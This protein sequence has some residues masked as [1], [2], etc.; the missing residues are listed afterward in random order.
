MSTFNRTQLKD[1]SVLIRFTQVYCQGQHHAPAQPIEILPELA[2]HFRHGVSLCPE[3]HR[4]L[5]YALHK[6][7]LCPLDPKPACKHCHI[8]CYSAEHRAK[9]REVM[10]FAGRQLIMRGRLHYLWHYFF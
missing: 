10:A 2:P 4:F 1:I 9:V 3:C 5:T 7:A 6:R 8:H